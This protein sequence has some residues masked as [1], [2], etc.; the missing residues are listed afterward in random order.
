MSVDL[1]YFLY[2]AYTAFRHE[3]S[4][5]DEGPLSPIFA[6]ARRAGSGAT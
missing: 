4:R 2:F 6:V 1:V 5:E 3:Y